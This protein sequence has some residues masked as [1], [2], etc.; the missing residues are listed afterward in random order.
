MDCILW[1]VAGMRKSRRSLILRLALA[2]SDEYISFHCTTKVAVLETLQSFSLYT[3]DCVC[4][5][6]YLL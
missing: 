1:F 4:V 3:D 2:S 5:A 6:L